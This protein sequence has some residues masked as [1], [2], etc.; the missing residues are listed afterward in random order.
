MDI[1][2]ILRE[3]NNIAIV[4]EFKSF[5]KN[6]IP[7]EIDIIAQDYE[8][9]LLKISEKCNMSLRYHRLIHKE[10]EEI[11]RNEEELQQINQDIDLLV[12]N[13]N[14]QK[15]IAFKTIETYQSEFESFFIKE[16]WSPETYFLLEMA[17]LLGIEINNDKNQC[18]EDL[19]KVYSSKKTISEALRRFF[20][21]KVFTLDVI[22]RKEME[23]M[24]HY[25]ERQ[26]ELIRGDSQEK[27]IKSFGNIVDCCIACLDLSS[28]KSSLESVL[29]SKREKLEIIR[30]EVQD[31][32]EASKIIDRDI[33]ISVKEYEKKKELYGEFLK[34]KEFADE[35]LARYKGYLSELNQER[36]KPQPN[37]TKI[38][39]I[40][41]S[42]HN[43]IRQMEILRKNISSQFDQAIQKI[44]TG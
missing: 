34:M 37:K 10:Q 9:H 7:K 3:D 2:P 40:I 23:D 43:E 27:L 8:S 36:N 42:L 20:S 25:Y 29:K 18:L 35:S 39:L 41:K 16:E 24:I 12:S 19:K 1:N 31:L 4:D 5:D 22:A 30:K 17:R 15:E 32:R 28:L 13:F 11:S 38:D 21:K 14:T 26:I 6:I 44:K 33:D